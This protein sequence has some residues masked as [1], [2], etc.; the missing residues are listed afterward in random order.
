VDEF[1]EKVPNL[2]KKHH[3]PLEKF[4]HL[5]FLWAIDV[6]VVVY[7]NVIQLLQ[8]YWYQADHLRSHKTLK[9]FYLLSKIEE[10][11]Y[12]HSLSVS[13]CRHYRHLVCD[14]RCIDHKEHM[15][16]DPQCETCLTYRKQEQLE[17]SLDNFQP[18]SWAY[19]QINA[20]KIIMFLLWWLW[21]DAV[22]SDRSSQKFR[23]NVL[24]PSSG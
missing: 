10:G 11:K 5:D 9:R 20:N 12:L 14:T 19:W 1:S 15:R 24:P 8:N 16:Q 7:E 23:R 6:E 2:V 22:E 21:C 17:K 13:S 3:V 18:N 4:N